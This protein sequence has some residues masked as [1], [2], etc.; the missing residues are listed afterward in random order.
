M[1]WNSCKT[2][3]SALV[4]G[5]GLTVNIFTVN[6]NFSQYMYLFP[7]KYKNHY[8][9]LPILSCLLGRW[10]SCDAT[11]YHCVKNLVY[12]VLKCSP[13][14]QKYQRTW[15]LPEPIHLVIHLNINIFIMIISPLKHCDQRE[16][17]LSLLPFI[18]QFLRYW[19]V[20]M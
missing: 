3:P 13:I 7:Q 6:L 4:L 18:F 9:K 16:V 1:N 15:D 2:F 11:Y 19:D 20:T 10:Y 17:T 12:L 5:H 8:L 14:W